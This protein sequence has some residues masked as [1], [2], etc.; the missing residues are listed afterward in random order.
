LFGKKKNLIDYF[1]CSEIRVIKG[2][3]NEAQGKF[4]FGGVNTQNIDHRLNL[5]AMEKLEK[6]RDGLLE[7]RDRALLV[8]R[9]ADSERHQMKAI[10]K[11]LQRDI[12]SLKEKLRQL[13]NGGNMSD[14]LDKAQQKYKVESSKYQSEV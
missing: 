13:E 2:Q 5:D 7:E 1:F 14:Q 4:G 8:K 6:Q 12:L 11:D 9:K 3:L 10:H